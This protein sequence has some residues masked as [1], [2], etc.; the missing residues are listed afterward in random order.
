MSASAVLLRL[1]LCL[2]LVLD[3]IGSAGASARMAVAA[4]GHPAAAAEPERCPSHPHAPEAAD[5]HAGH[6]APSPAAA[7]AKCA[8]HANSHCC[9]SAACGC[10]CAQTGSTAMFAAAPLAL[11]FLPAAPLPSASAGRAAPVLAPSIRPP[12]A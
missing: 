4:T 10:A 2:V 9:D 8:D 6:H 1:L 12:I 7:S 11:A 5:P 3:G